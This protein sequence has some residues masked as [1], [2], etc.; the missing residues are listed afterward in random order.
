MNGQAAFLHLF[1]DIR[2][3]DVLV[4][5]L[6]AGYLL[7]QIK[8]G[9]LWLRSYVKQTEQDEK[10]LGDAARLPDYH[11]QSIDIRNRLQKQIDDI[12]QDVID[13]KA[14]QSRNEAM[15]LGLQAILR[16]YII[17]NYNK[18]RDKG[19]MPIYARESVKKIYEAYE[20]LGGNDVAHNLYEKMLSWD[21]E[22]GG[23]PER[24]EKEDVEQQSV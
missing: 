13:I 19:Y 2:V 6:A 17:S 3:T 7:P 24:K 1:G 20:G 14:S 4:F 15:S 8:K 10:A 5:I 12:Q 9:Y 11:K 16:D 23:E 21:T 22:P 18:Y